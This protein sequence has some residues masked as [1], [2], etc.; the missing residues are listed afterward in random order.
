VAFALLFGSIL[1]G[2]GFRDVDVA[3]YLSPSLE[4]LEGLE[5]AFANR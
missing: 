3:I 1:E 5:E 2:K 4:P